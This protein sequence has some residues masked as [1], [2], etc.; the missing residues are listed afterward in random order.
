MAWFQTDLLLTTHLLQF[1]LVKIIHLIVIANWEIRSPTSNTNLS[2]FLL[3]KCC[4]LIGPIV[5]AKGF[6]IWCLHKDCFNSFIET[7][8]SNLPKSANAILLCSALA[9]EPQFL[10]CINDTVYWVLQMAAGLSY[11]LIMQHHRWG[12]IGPNIWDYQS[13]IMFIVYILI[14]LLVKCNWLFLSKIKEFIIKTTFILY[15]NAQDWHFT[16]LF[17]DTC[18]CFICRIKPNCSPLCLKITAALLN[19]AA[20]AAG[21]GLV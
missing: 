7:R 20:S 9:A 8:N 12:E 1:W 17:Q 2:V 13:L 21:P 14:I 11:P 5:V 3:N 10:V 18:W 15:T 16:I 4:L 19:T 6:M